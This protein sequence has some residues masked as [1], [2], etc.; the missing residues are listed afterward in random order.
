MR[1]FWRVLVFSVLLA[2]VPVRAEVVAVEPDALESLGSDAGPLVPG[3]N[4]VSLSAV[5]QQIARTRFLIVKN[6]AEERVETPTEIVG[7]DAGAF[8][9][10]DPPLELA[11]GKKGR[12]TLAFRPIRGA[13]RY[14]AG[15]QIGSGENRRFVVLQGIGLEAFEGENEP[16]LQDIVSA[17]GM[18]LDVGGASLSLDTQ[19]P[20]IGDGVDCAYFR[21][22]GS[23]KVR[24][25]PLARFSPPGPTPV[26]IFTKG[27]EALQEL[28]QLAKSTGGYPDAHQALL[29]PLKGE[30]KSIEFEPGDA[31]FGF[32]M[33]GHHYTSFTDPER[34]T[35]AAIDHTARIF[36]I[37]SF[38]GRALEHAWM[39]AFEEAK[40]G[41]YQDVVLMVENVMP[42]E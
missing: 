30:S 32:Y 18:A 17:F 40:N 21:M 26:G 23:G 16:P 31:A 29:P 12:W 10:I 27:E 38:Q 15:L 41:D 2:G 35:K 36:P 14:T 6:V 4:L 20:V 37:S 19:A 13:G 22:A 24:I 33:K 3:R 9:V 42:V 7:S 8:E 11:A 34:P 5:S 25:T 28:G 39:I 1:F